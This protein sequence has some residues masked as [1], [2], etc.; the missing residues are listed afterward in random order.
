MKETIE[1]NIRG[2]DYKLLTEHPK[3]IVL[4]AASF[5]EQIIRE[6][7]EEL[8]ELRNETLFLLA[9]LNVSLQLKQEEKKK[10]EIERRIEDLLRKIDKILE[11]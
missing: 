9:G 5:L 6:I 1:V 7:E 11:K 3:E 8:G 4:E 2:R 10:R